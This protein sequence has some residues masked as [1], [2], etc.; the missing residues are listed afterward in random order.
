MKTLKFK[1]TGKHPGLLMNNA[2]YLADPLSPIK[3]EIQSITS[4]R[5]KTDEDYEKINFLSWKA[6]LYFDEKLKYYIPSENIDA[7]LWNA[8]KKFKLGKAYKEACMLTDDSKLIF[9]H[10]E[11]PPGDLYR[12][13]DYVDLRS[14]GQRGNRIM[15]CRPHFPKWSLKFEL[16]ID[17]SVID[18]NQI[19]DI[20][21]AAGSYIGLCDYRPRFGRFEVKQI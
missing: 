10:S 6:S 16:W 17:D 8:A 4:K 5:K 15:R 20:V 7:T 11:V 2:R 3:K 9:D 12:L 13:A 1:L 21:N 18:D 19:V 14:I